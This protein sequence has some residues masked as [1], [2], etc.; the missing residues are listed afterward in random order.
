MSVDDE[1]HAYVLSSFSLSQLSFGLGKSVVDKGW[2]GG[3]DSFS[4][5]QLSLGVEMSLGLCSL[6]LFRGG[7][8]AKTFLSDLD[9]EIPR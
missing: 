4:L 3:L 2:T 7:T 8:R 9:A 5:K 6:P 1:R